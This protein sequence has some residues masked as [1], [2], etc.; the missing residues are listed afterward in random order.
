LKKKGGGGGRLVSKP[1]RGVK[2][3]LTKQLTR[4][5]EKLTPHVENAGE[6]YVERKRSQ[7]GWDK[8]PV[9]Q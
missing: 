4:K 2:R 6:E 7:G 1:L 3:L 9:K 8:N 5:V